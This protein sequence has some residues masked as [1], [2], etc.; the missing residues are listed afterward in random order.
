MRVMTEL[1]IVF[2][3]GGLPD[4]AEPDAATL[5]RWRRRY[6]VALDR[7]REA[8]IKTIADEASG[9]ETYVALRAKWDR[10]LAAFADHMVHS[11]DQIDPVGANPDRAT[12]RPEFTQRLRAAG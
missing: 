1:A 7:L 5:D 6:R 4:V 8:G 12:E 9:A 2:L 10:Y 3:P 11:M